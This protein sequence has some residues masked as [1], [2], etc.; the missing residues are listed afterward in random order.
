VR[1][2]ASRAQAHAAL[3]AD[4]ESAASD[5]DEGKR[6]KLTNIGA[7]AEGLNFLVLPTDNYDADTEV[8]EFSLGGVVSFVRP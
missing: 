5:A 1:K 8:W 6:S 7:M 2:F 4:G 3:I